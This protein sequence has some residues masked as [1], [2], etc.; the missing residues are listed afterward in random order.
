[1]KICKNGIWDSTIPGI[2][3]DAHDESNYSKLFKKM[4]DYYPRNDESLVK[5][6]NI[7]NQAKEQGKGKNYDCIV[8][9]SGGTD[10]TYLLH[11]LV[12]QYG[13]RPLAVTFDNGWSSEISIQNIKLITSK[14]NV[15][16]ETYVVDY[17]EMK[18]IIVSFMK[19]G[20]PWIDGPTDHAIKALMHKQARKE[21]IKFV[22]HGSDFRTEGFQPNE[23]T[24][25]DA[26]QIKYINRKF[27]KIKIRSFPIISLFEEIYSSF[28][29]GVKLHRPFYYLPYNKSEAQQFIKNEYGWRYYGGHHHENS[30]TKFVITDWLPKKFNIDKRIITL[31]ALVM[32]GE[33]SREDALIEIKKDHYDI[34]LMRNHR[35]FVIKK[36]G[37]V[38]NQFNEIWNNKNRNFKNYPSYYPFIQKMSRIVNILVKYILPYK[39]LSLMQDEIRKSEKK[40]H[41]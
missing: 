6:D 13:L 37:L 26:R 30:F 11:L 27:G 40:N 1:M 38:N 7:V 20:L 17:E 5:W 15:D 9:V 25:C 28:I 36:L 34:E 3:F 24:H 32:S 31:S 10:S 19:A 35:E 16:L 21:G 14:L 4:L 41:E 18:D 23:W 2:E 12:R 33:M 8:G 29:C 39:P 22:F